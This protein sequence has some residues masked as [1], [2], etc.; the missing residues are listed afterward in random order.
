ME[1]EMIPVESSMI[2]EVGYDESTSDMHVV[3][4]GSYAHYVYHGV[5]VDTFA[6]VL[7]ASSVG[8]AINEL[9]RDQYVYDRLD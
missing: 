6:M 5:S 3:F 1:F 8:R 4:N 2:L 7:G 9:V